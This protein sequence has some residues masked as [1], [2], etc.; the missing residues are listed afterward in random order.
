MSPQR[1][2]KLR[3]HARNYNRYAVP[4]TVFEQKT[5]EAVATHSIAVTARPV[6]RCHLLEYRIDGGCSG[7]LIGDLYHQAI[8]RRINREMALYE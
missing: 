4:C 6:R 3:T 5:I 1:P 7:G 8:R 2:L